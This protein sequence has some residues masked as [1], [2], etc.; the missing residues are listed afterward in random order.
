MKQTNQID[1]M[2]QLQNI[3]YKKQK[4][5]MVL[6]KD[7][8]LFS[9]K[10]IQAYVSAPIAQVRIEDVFFSWTP[11]LS[12]ALPHQLALYKLMHPKTAKETQLALKLQALDK[13]FAEDKSTAN[14]LMSMASTYA[15]LPNTMSSFQKKQISQLEVFFSYAAIYIIREFWGSKFHP[16][17]KIN[18]QLKPILNAWS[19]QWL[20]VYKLC[21]HCRDFLS[22]TELERL[23][24]A[25]DWLEAIVNEHRQAILTYLFT[26]DVEKNT[27]GSI[28]SDIRDFVEHLK[29]GITPAKVDFE[30]RPYLYRLL[31]ISVP[32]ADVGKGDSLFYKD[33]WEPYISSLCDWANIVERSSLIKAVWSRDGGTQRENRGRGRMRRR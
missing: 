21:Q 3:F 30:N 11:F 12:L 19:K 31:E 29:Q 1:E 5:G 4:R 13:V 7:K 10:V 28:A 26:N 2:S 27:K 9:S 25:G 18:N 20:Q 14:A 6:E 8:D 17:P 23:P 24:K 16:S 15:V 32:L 22:D 33:Y